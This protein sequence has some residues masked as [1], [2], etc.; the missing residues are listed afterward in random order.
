ML[1][2]REEKMGVGRQCSVGHA[3]AAVVLV[4]IIRASLC[5]AAPI[6]FDPERTFCRPGWGNISSLPDSDIY[7]HCM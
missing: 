5:V 1:R 3:R 2:L 7:T 4:V 6:S